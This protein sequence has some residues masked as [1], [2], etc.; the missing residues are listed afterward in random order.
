[1]TLHGTHRSRS[2]SAPGAHSPPPS[3]PPASPSRARRTPSLSA[4]PATGRLRLR[5]HDQLADGDARRRRRDRQRLRA[6]A[7]AARRSRP[8][9]RW[10]GSAARPAPSLEG[11]RRRGLL[12]RDLRQCLASSPASPRCPARRP[13]PAPY[14]VLASFAGSA[15]YTA[16]LG[17]G[18]LHHR[19]G[20]ADGDR[21]RPGRHATTA[22]R[23]PPRPPSP[24]VSGSA[25]SSLEGVTPVARPITAGPTPDASQ[26]AGLI[27]QS[28]APTSPARTPSWPASPAAPTMPA[29]RRWPTSPSPRRRRRSAS[30]TPAAPINGTAFAATAPSPGVSGSAGPSLEGV[31]PSLTYYSGTYSSASQL[32]G[33]S[34]LSARADQAG[35]YTVAGQLRRQHRLRRRLAARQLHHRPGTPTVTVDGPGRHV[36]RLGA[37][38]HGDRR[39]DRRCGRPQPRGRDAVAHLLQWDL[40]HRSRSSPGLTP[41]G[42]RADARP[43][44]TPSWPASPAARTTAPARQLADFTITQATP[45]GER[46]RRGRH[47]TTARPSPPR[48]PSPGSDGTACRQPGGRQS[49]ADLLQRDLHQRRAARRPAPLSAAPSHAGPVHRPGQLRRQHRLRAGILPL[50]LHH[51]PGDCRRWPSPTP[52][53]PTTARPSPPRPRWPGSSPARTALLP[54]AWRAPRPR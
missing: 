21:R 26:L 3:T 2:R 46:H 20:D 1:M 25:G 28:A 11:S 29:P 32:T 51:R 15:D 34:P 42:Y 24:G 50:Q 13:R 39:R 27:P 53:A 45:D 52:A 44:R 40:H 49:V 18:Q 31:T 38:R 54:P 22:R 30:P 19:P 5:Q 43:A 48:P 7:T 14:T 17:T 9:P 10:P 47:V 36:Q 23:S 6:A 4:T 8:R 12:Q 35:A 37:P 16:R 41:L 33:L